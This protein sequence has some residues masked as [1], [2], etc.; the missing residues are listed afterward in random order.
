MIVILWAVVSNIVDSS[1]KLPSPSETFH[2]LLRIISNEN[3]ITQIM[4]SLNRVM[5]GYII[6]FVFAVMLGMVAGFVLPFYYLLKPLFLIM[7]AMPTMATILLS[8]IWF[9]REISPILVGILIVFPIVYSSVVN[10]IRNLDKQLLEMVEIYQLNFSNK[11]KHLYLPS[12]RSSLVSV[13]AATMGL[14]IKVNIAAE[15]LSQPRFSIGT[16]FQM[17]KVALNTSGVIAWA[18]ITIIIA[19]FFELAIERIGKRWQH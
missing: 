5:I 12:I 11:L 19:A 16:G 6:A 14:N 10:N 4:N 1:I 2:S 15:V 3:F 7:R 18:V 13:A 17:E 9:K 8:L